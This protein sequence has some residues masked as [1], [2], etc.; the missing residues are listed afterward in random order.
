MLLRGKVLVLAHPRTA[1]TGLRNAL[2][3]LGGTQI[4]PHHVGRDDPKVRAV[5]T[6]EPVLTVIRNPYD[7]LVSW[8]LVRTFNRP[9]PQPNLADFAKSFRDAKGNFIRDGKI[10][11]HTPTADI[12]VRYESLTPDLNLALGQCGVEPVTLPWLNQTGGKDKPWRD[13]YD[14]AAI[15]AANHRFGDEAVAHGYDL[16]S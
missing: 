15:K 10:L 2:I 3:E 9:Q 16:L 4:H 13:Y 5:H 1:S 6:D 8:W 11:Y 12:V 14:Q 7:A